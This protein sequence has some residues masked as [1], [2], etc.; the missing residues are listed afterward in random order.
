MSDKQSF[1]MHLNFWE[2]IKTLSMEE[3]GKLLTAIFQAQT[4]EKIEELSPAANMAYQFIIQQINADSEKYKKR[5]KINAENG[6]YGRAGKGKQTDVNT[7]EKNKRLISDSDNDNDIDLFKKDLS[8]DK[9]KKKKFV[10]PAI[11]EVKKYCDERKNGIDPERFLNFYES[12]GW[13]V[14]KS[15]MKD[16]KAAVRT[17]EDTQKQEN[18][19]KTQNFGLI[20]VNQG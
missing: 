6:K 8:E 5:C 15:P 18:A 16:W 12:K 2:P 14:G 13:L 19:P 1:L 7:T 10:P 20:K 11:D 17:W 9:S 3:R 4:A